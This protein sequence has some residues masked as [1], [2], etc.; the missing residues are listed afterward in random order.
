[1]K[2]YGPEDSHASGPSQRIT[3]RWHWDGHRFVR[4]PM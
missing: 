1:M 4:L 3:V 2:A